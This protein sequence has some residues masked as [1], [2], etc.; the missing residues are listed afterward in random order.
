VSGGNRPDPLTPPE[1]YGQKPGQEEPPDLS[2]CASMTGPDE[3]CSVLPVEVWWTGCINE[4]VGPVAWCE[5]HA[6]QVSAYAGYGITCALCKA[7][8]T[9]IRRETMDGQPLPLRKQDPRVQD[10]L[11]ASALAGQTGLDRARDA[12]RRARGGDPPA[13]IRG[14]G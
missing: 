8:I 5:A 7:L 13:Q 4:H 6:R 3:H 11:D 10:A 14:F 12:V 1:G 9:V 2:V